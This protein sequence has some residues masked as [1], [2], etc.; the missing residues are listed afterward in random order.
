VHC[1][2]VVVGM[3]PGGEQVARKLAEAGLHV[4]GIEAELLGRSARA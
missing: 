3:V 2:V 4:V 1:D